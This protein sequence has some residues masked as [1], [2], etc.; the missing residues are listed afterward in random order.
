MV[1]DEDDIPYSVRLWSKSDRGW[2]VPAY[3]G[4]FTCFEE[5]EAWEYMLSLMNAEGL[6][7]AS[8]TYKTTDA[9]SWGVYLEKTKEKADPL[10]DSEEEIRRVWGPESIGTGDPSAGG[11]IRDVLTAAL[12]AP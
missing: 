1:L 3:I 9:G 5:R 11:M 8:W 10:S 4:E 6:S 12:S 2:G 7:Y